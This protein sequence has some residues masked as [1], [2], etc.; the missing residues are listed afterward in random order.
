[1]TITES[2][3]IFF[4]PAGGTKQ[5]SDIIV[6]A[7]R[8]YFKNTAS[9]QPEFVTKSLDLLRNPPGSFK[10]SS[11]LTEG[12]LNMSE[13]SLG[14]E[15]IVKAECLT[16]VCV[17]VYSGRI[18]EAAASMLRCLKGDG[19]PL[20]A[21]AVYGNRD[22]D[23]ALLELTDL[24]SEQ[25]FWVTGAAAALA[26]H[27]IFP[28]VAAGRPDGQDEERLR[29]FAQNCLQ[30]L[31]EKRAFGENCKFEPTIK[32]NRP[33]RES[34]SV[35]VKPRVKG[36]CNSCG[37]CAGLCPVQAIDR[38]DCRK[39]DKKKCISCGACIKNCPRHMRHYGGLIYSIGA[40]GFKKKF[41][42]RKEPEFF[43]KGM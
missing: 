2:L 30:N 9:A 35:P 34:A 6:G 43:Y 22:Y 36:G 38:T 16:T 41:S 33:Y 24:M 17:P 11:G 12:A 20:I 39:F 25:G 42:V 10:S 37:I 5:V 40:A 1:M 19:A 15:L 3:H 18:P 7:V 13:C 26:E 32:G 28:E 23:D 29:G 8:D 4:S 31:Q 27:S 21:V 14:Q